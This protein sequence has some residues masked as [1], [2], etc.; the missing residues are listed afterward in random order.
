MGLL[1]FYATFY[2]GHCGIHL[3]IFCLWR[4]Q[5]TKQFLCELAQDDQDS[6]ATDELLVVRN[7]ISCMV[8]TKSVKSDHNLV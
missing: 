4:L 2:T 8:R 3:S 1:F 6:I 5:A 7:C